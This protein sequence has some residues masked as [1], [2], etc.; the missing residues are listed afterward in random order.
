M[1]IYL[2][3]FKNY[4]FLTKK[5]IAEA[6]NT[7]FFFFNSNNVYKNNFIINEVLAHNSSIYSFNP[8]YSTSFNKAFYIFLMYL[9]FSKS[10][11]LN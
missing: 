3:F 9:I 7:S 2:K 6:N 5:N 4:L 1:P 10:V 11:Y 8:I